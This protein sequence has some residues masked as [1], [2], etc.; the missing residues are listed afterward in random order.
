VKIGDNEM[1]RAAR[2]WSIMV[3]MAALL[4]SV[5]EI[6]NFGHSEGIFYSGYS[7]VM[8]KLKGPCWNDPSPECELR[9]WK[10]K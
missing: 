6:Y 10:Q 1:V 7:A 9:V 2:A 8:E 5:I 3:G 4:A